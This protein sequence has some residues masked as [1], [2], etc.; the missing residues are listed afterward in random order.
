VTRKA[1]ARPACA[2]GNRFAL[3]VGCGF[4]DVPAGVGAKGL[5]S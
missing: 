1:A 5:E 4:D 3:A 2:V